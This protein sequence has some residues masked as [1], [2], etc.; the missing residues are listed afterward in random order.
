MIFVVFQA[1]RKSTKISFLGPETS[2][3][4][5][6][7]L[8]EGVVAEEFVPSLESLFS[9][10]FEGRNLGCPEIFAVVSWTPGGVQKLVQKKFLRIVRSLVFGF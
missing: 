6:V 3:W 2:R 9:L 10:G 1:R 8:R 4:G 5:G 7:L